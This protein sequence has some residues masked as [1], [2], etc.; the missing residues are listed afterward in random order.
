MPELWHP[1]LSPFPVRSLIF[2]GR[3]EFHPFH[4][5]HNFAVL[6]FQHQARASSTFPCMLNWHCSKTLCHNFTKQAGDTLNLYL[7]L[8]AVYTNEAPCQDAKIV[9]KNP[10]C[11]VQH[12]FQELV[13]SNPRVALLHCCLTGAKQLSFVIGWLHTKNMCIFNSNLNQKECLI[14][15]MA[16]K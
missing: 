13:S 2:L 16:F 6:H 4:I 5:N 15:D 8:A 1:F 14:P 11:C 3:M 7:L 9:F 12:T 10:E